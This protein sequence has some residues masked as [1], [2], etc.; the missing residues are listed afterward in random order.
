VIVVAKQFNPDNIRI[1]A[2]DLDGTTLNEGVMS[3]EVQNALAALTARGIAVVV[4]TGRDICQIPLRV[5]GCF[6]YRITTNGGSV[7]DSEG[8][9][10]SEHPIDPKTAREALHIIHKGKGYSCLYYNG[11][12][13]ASLGFLYRIITKTNYASKSHRKS[14]K[15]VRKGTGKVS[16]RMHRL[17]KK[18]GINIYKIQSFFKTREDADR[19]AEMLKAHG[20]LNPVVVEDL[21]M[22]TTFQN[23]SKA[24][25]LLELCKKLNCTPENIVAF[26]DSA[27]DLEMLKL[28]GY[29]VGMGNAE[30]CVKSQV[31]YVTGPVTEDGVAEAIKVLFSL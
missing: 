30:T 25:G 26:G 12:V 8:N 9:I 4:S 24:H 14:T 16:F 27:N 10:I 22:E 18:Q 29:S 17:V 2:F 11:F 15:D 13:L 5:L 6:E 21:G 19:T 20:R 3:A 7:T 23:V 1:A 28:A 31:D